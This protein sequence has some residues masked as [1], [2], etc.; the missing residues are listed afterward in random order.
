MDGDCDKDKSDDDDVG[1]VEGNVLSSQ[2]LSN[3]TFTL[4]D[5]VYVRC[6]G[7]QK[8]LRQK[9]PKENKK[10]TYTI[11]KQTRHVR[12]NCPSHKQARYSICILRF[13]MIYIKKKFD[14]IHIKFLFSLGIL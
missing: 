3:L 1:S 13:T 8:S 2:V 10:R 12:T 5:P 6:R 7:K 9:N 11:C 14:L 4:Q